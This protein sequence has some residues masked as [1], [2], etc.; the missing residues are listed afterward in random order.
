MTLT[1]G[2]DLPSAR[3]RSI[4]SERCETRMRSGGEREKNHFTFPIAN[5]PVASRRGRWTLAGDS[6]MPLQFLLS[7]ELN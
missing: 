4:E 2:L 6:R 1:L 3:S 5:R 7:F